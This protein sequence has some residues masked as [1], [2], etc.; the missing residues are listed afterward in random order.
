MI[1]NITDCGTHKRKGTHQ[2]APIQRYPSVSHGIRGKR[3][4]DTNGDG[5]P[6]SREFAGSHRYE[7][8]VMLAERFAADEGSISTVI[9]ASGESQ[10]DAV[11][12]SGLAGHLNAPVLLTRS[13]RLPHN[14]A[15][16]I[17]EQNITNVV[18]VGG[19]SAVSDAVR[20]RI[21]GLGSKPS[22]KRIAGDDRYDTA[23]R[24]GSDLGGP[25]PTWCGSD[26]PAAILVNGGDAGRADA[27]V[28]GPLAFALGLPVLL[29]ADD[30]IPEATSD[31]LA[32][33]KV[34]HVVIVGGRAA[35]SDAVDEA[36]VEDVGV[37]NTRRISGGSAAAT[38]VDVA[39][40]MLGNCAE[41]L[42]TNR[43]RVA[44]VG[45]DAI[46]D[47]IAAAPVM[48]RGIGDG[49]PVPILLVGD[50]LPAAVSD[51]LAGTPEVRAGNK[52]HLRI[53]AIGGTAAV[54][55]G[56][57]QAAVDAAKTSPELTAEITPVKDASGAY[58]NQFKVTFSDDV[59]LAVDGPDT[60]ETVGE[61]E[62]RGTVED[63]TMYELNGRRLEAES[64]DPEDSA[65]V[66]YVQDLVFTAD[67][68]ITITLSHPLEAGDIIT[69]DNSHNERRGQRLGANNDM[70]TLE[71]AELELP[72]V[73]L[74]VDRTAPVVKIIA[75]PGQ[76]YFDVLVYEESNLILNEL[77]NTGATGKGPLTAVSRRINDWVTFRPE[78]SPADET[79]TDTTTAGAAHTPRRIT[80]NAALAAQ[81]AS[82]GGSSDDVRMR[83]TIS[84]QNPNDEPPP[85]GQF[86]DAAVPQVLRAGDVIFIKGGAF[87]DASPSALRSQAVQYTVPPVK[88][89]TPS[90]NN[91]GTG[92]LM[93]TSVSI[94]DR[95]PTAQATALIGDATNGQQLRITAKKDGVAKGAA[96]NGW[97][98]FGYDDRPA[99][100]AS[101]NRFEIDVDV[102]VAN[103][104]IA[105]TISDAVPTRPLAGGQGPTL[106]DLASKLWSDSDFA[107][108]FTV[109]YAAPDTQVKTTP[110]GATPAA[111]V[112]LENGRTSVGVVVKFNAPIQTLLGNEGRDLAED[113]APKFTTGL[114]LGAAAT[115]DDPDAVAISFVA[116]DDVIHISYTS[117]SLVEL[118]ARTGF[119]VI[120]DDLVQGWFDGTRIRGY[121][122]PTIATVT[123][124][125]AAD[126]LTQGRPNVRYLLSS[127]R[128]DSSI[129]PRD[130]K[131]AA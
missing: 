13:S 34:E 121:G 84:V 130:V 75:V 125:F 98:V 5:V 61:A 78:N 127:L 15:R 23:A 4:T 87:R 10:V 66:A 28:I 103:Q 82:M 131:P 115:N 64:D 53:H 38:S 1:T 58:T 65:E 104:R 37:V 79:V 41:V 119:R 33:N 114:T 126:D 93:I 32:D 80:V 111:G 73:T 70:R 11:T 52:T 100:A 18:I 29:T 7:T 56:V 81:V 6:D 21:E 25:N 2:T 92:D 63:P 116:P 85:A 20:T 55:A 112:P 109:G 91:K 71:R 123:G 102:D 22:V 42:G 46:A 31:F 122:G 113:I 62:R 16:F 94:G 54:S 39:T 117:D 17:D 59:K 27:V 108:N 128:L 97:I 57:M 8:A 60:G 95:S 120:A 3:L 106:A 99:G 24:I 45:R 83:F 43:D 9:V 105:Y 36:L 47:G 110:L 14:V 86:A 48:G 129:K 30:E 124:A 90:S 51:Y 12:A 89:N 101:S 69:V 35:V 49:G 107:A 50:D 26:A 44:L 74:P 77:G 118:P 68:T 96:G 40:E 19:T 72:A 88:T 67:R 76:N